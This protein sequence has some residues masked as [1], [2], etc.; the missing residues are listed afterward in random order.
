MRRRAKVT[1]YMVPTS[2]NA[3]EVNPM[4]SRLAQEAKAMRASVVVLD[5]HL[6]ALEAIQADL[7]TAAAGVIRAINEDPAFVSVRTR[8]GDV[9]AQVR[10]AKADALET[11]VA[12]E[13][14]AKQ[15]E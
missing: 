4:V 2:E 12:L 6:V 11:I 7:D 5:K 9:Y 14:Y 13:E 1:R 15:L 8:T 10:G 3:L